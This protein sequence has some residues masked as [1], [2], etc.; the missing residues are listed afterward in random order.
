MDLVNRSGGQEK[1]NLLL[2]V[3]FFLVSFLA[4]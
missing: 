1:L 4:F 2:Q 3:I